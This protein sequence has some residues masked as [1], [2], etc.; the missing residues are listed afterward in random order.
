MN[1]QLVLLIVLCNMTCLR[2]SR[3]LVSLFAIELGAPQYMIGVMIALYALFPAMLAV[4]AGRLSDRIGPR[5]PMIGGTAGAVIGL[6]IPFLA[7]GLLALCLSA[8]VFGISFVFYHVTVQSMLG[9]ISSDATR[10]RNFSNYS[11]MIAAGGS[12]GPLGAGFSIDH[13]GFGSTYLYLALLALIPL[14]LL[15]TSRALRDTSIPAAAKSDAPAETR[16]TGD[17]LRHKPLRS[18]LI[19]STAILT[20]TDL[21]EFYM[22]IYGH[23]IG[24]SASECG[25]VLSTMGVAAFVVR[26]VMPWLSRRIGEAPLLAW[27]LFLGAGAFLVFPLFKNMLVLTIFAFLLG[28]SLG[29]GQ[30]LSTILIYARSPQGRTGEALG[31]RLAINNATHVIIPLAAGSIG[32]VFGVGPVFWINAMML[33]GG[34][35]LVRRGSA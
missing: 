34:G 33:A 27:S 20:G 13:F 28:L 21:F 2:A 11:L 14:V 24:L 26:I 12:L 30:P 15:A 4:Y 22:P 7:P 25:F 35:V 5:W 31:L 1:V 10:T 3:I 19:G 32:S 6:L 18:P 23:S 9:A 16:A 8:L 29:C 17:L